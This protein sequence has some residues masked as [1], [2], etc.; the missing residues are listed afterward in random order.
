[1]VLH[2]SRFVFYGSSSVFMVFHDSRSVFHGFRSVYGF[3]GFQVG[4]S[5]LR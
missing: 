2:G 4:F 3:S 5:W 1:M